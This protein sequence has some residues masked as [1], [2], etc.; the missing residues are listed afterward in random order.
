MSFL[1]TEIGRESKR[2]SRVMIIGN[3]YTSISELAAFM[4]EVGIETSAVSTGDWSVERL[5]EI[6]QGAVIVEDEP[7]SRG[8]DISSEIRRESS[9]PIIMVGKTDNEIAWV[10]A[11]SYGVDFY[12][13][14]PFNHHELVARIRALIRR[15]EHNQRK[16][17]DAK[18]RSTV[19]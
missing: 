6:L 2:D 13:A 14:R 15:R 4:K 5:D 16:F 7:G 12:L 10:K 18:I 1:T 11:A 19:Y 9:V 17:T 3:D 8:W